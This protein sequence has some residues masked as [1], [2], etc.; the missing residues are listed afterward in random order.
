[1]KFKV[2]HIFLLV[3]ITIFTIACQWEKS[4]KVLPPNVLLVVT[5][6]QAYGD[7]SMNEN[8]ITETP[9]IDKLAKEGAYANH[10]YVSP[11]CAPTRASLLTGRYHQ[12]TGV[13]GVTRGREDMRLDEVTI[14][15]VFKSIGYQTG[16][17]GKWHNGAHYPYHPLGR[18][19]DEFVG[20]TSGHWSNYFNTTIE[21]NG[22]PFKAKGY[23]PDV[24][25]DEAISFIEN[26]NTEGKPFLCYVPYQTP[27]TPLQVPDKYFDKYKAKGADDFNACIYGMCE[28]IDDNVGRLLS[29]LDKLKVRDNTIVIYL[30]DNGPLNFRFNYDLKGRKGQV[31]EGGVRVPFIIS[32]P[33]HIKKG[34]VIDEA[35]AHIDVLPTLLSLVNAEYK[36]PKPLDGVSFKSLLMGDT[37]FPKRFLLNEFFGRKRVLADPYLMVENALFDIRN[38]AGQRYDLSSDKPALYDSLK[39]VFDTWFKEASADQV[40]EKSIPVGYDAYPITTLPAHEADLFPPFEARKDR[41]HTGIAY[42]SL[43]GW[44]HDWIDFWTNTE[45]YA[46]W[47]IDVVDEAVYNLEI[48][49]ALADQDIGTQ[50][51]LTIGDVSVDFVVD[52]SFVHSD[53]K[54]YDRVKREQ[55]APETDWGKL[56]IGKVCLEKGKCDV[57]IQAL[58]IPGKKTIELKEIQLIKN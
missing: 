16:I 42:H 19:F 39:K 4:D 47:Q 56:N 24:L 55:E 27:H 35:L 3:G 37:H 38:D 58:D 14:G 44:A 36:F 2:K 29:T 1:M 9:V 28:N 53:F 45:A 43:Y 51:K 6:D 30:S 11:V 12:R 5:D 23:L 31:D 52:K 8:T 33:N 22:E 26:A 49:Y 25:T 7:L 10:F 15:D 46:Q 41:R 21:K 32:W 17:F 34:L 50:L 48:Y 54:D 57:T 13:S 18:G 40:K 20:F